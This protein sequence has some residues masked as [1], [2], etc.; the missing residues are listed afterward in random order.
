M[1]VQCANC[2]QCVICLMYALIFQCVILFF[3]FVGLAFVFAVVFLYSFF[4]LKMEFLTLVFFSIKNAIQKRL[5]PIVY[6]RQEHFKIF[7]KSDRDHQKLAGL[8]QEELQSKSTKMGRTQ[9][10]L[11]LTVQTDVD[12]PN[13]LSLER[14]KRHV[15]RFF[16]TILRFKLGKLIEFK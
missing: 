1:H 3:F 12:C 13:I 4:N 8:R 11:D 16:C 6:L 7:T 10:K 9:N 15:K 14:Y 2:F 5:T